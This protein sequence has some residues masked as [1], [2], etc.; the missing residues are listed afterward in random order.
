MSVGPLPAPVRFH[1]NLTHGQAHSHAIRSGR[2]KWLKQLLPSRIRATGTGISNADF[3]H[4]H[5]RA[6]GGNNEIM[7]WLVLH[8]LD[9]ARVAFSQSGESLFGFARGD[10]NERN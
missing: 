2:D 3:H 9:R 5:L 10:V 7:V 4:A 1:D 8:G 6:F